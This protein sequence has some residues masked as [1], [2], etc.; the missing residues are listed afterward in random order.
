MTRVENKINL[1]LDS[2]LNHLLPPLLSPSNQHRF[3]TRTLKHT[4]NVFDASFCWISVWVDGSLVFK[5]SGSSLKHKRLITSKQLPK[6]P[7]RLLREIY[8]LMYSSRSESAGNNEI[9]F[10]FFREQKF[11]RF[12]GVPLM[13]VKRLMG[14]LNLVRENKSPAFTPG[15][16]NQLTLL[17]NLLS[18]IMCQWA[19]E[20]SQE[21][22]E[23]TFDSLPQPVIIKDQMHR[24]VAINQ[25]LSDLMGYPQSQILGKSEYDLLPPAQA[26]FFRKKDEEAFRTGKIVDISERSVTDRKGTIHNVQAKRAPLRDP[27]GRITHLVEIMEDTTE[28]KRTERELIKKE[29]IAR[30]RAL[31][32]ND[33][34]TLFIK[35]QVL[36]RACKTIR[37]SGLFQRAVMT[38]HDNTR[39]IIHLGQVGLPPKLIQRAQ[40]APPLERNQISRIMQKRFRISDSFF[41]PVEAGIDF[42]RNRR[43]IP[44]KKHSPPG[45]WQ[46]GD[47]LFVPLRDFSGKVMGYLSVDTPADGCR[48]DIKKVQSLEMLAEAAASRIRELDAQKA[49]QTS[50]DKLKAMFDSVADGITVT[51]LNGK[52]TQSNHS[53]I[54]MFGYKD[55]TEVIGR[56]VFEFIHP[57]DL[58]IAKERFSK[59]AKSGAIASV[60]YTCLKKDGSEFPVELSAAAIRNVRGTPTNLVGILKDITGRKKAEEE[61]FQSQARYKALIEQIPAH[62]YT[63]SVDKI[64][65]SLYISPQVEKLIGYTQGDFRRDPDLW[66]KRLHPADKKRVLSELRHSHA[67]G[68]PFISEYR[69]IHR[70]GNTVWVRDEAMLVLDQKGKPLVL[71]G[72]MTNIT[73]RKSA[74][75]ER[76]KSEEKYR[77]VV[78]NANEAIVVAQEGYL[79][80]VNPKMIEIL[81][82]PEKELLSQPFT[83]FIHPADRKMVVERHWKRIKGEEVPSIYDFRVI[84]RKGDVKWLEINAVTIN[85]GNQPATLNFLTDIT[86]R[87]QD[88]QLKSKYQEQKMLFELTQALSTAGD[89]NQ[90]LKIATKKVVE[91]MGIERSSIVLVNP[92][93][94]SAT[95]NTLYAKKGKANSKLM[96]YTFKSDIYIQL[97][98]LILRKPFVS[99][100]TSLLPHG[101]FLRDFFKQLGIKSNLSVSLISRDK[102][103][104]CINIATKEKHHTF[105]PAEIRLLQMIANTIAVIIENYKF[106]E[107]LKSQSRLLDAQLKEQKMLFELTQALS[108]ATDIKQLKKISVQT[109]AKLMHAERV[110]MGI[111]TAKGDSFNVSDL[112][113]RGKPGHPYSLSL[114]K[115]MFVDQIK[116]LMRRKQPTIVNDTSIYPPGSLEREIISKRGIKSAVGVPLTSHGKVFGF[117]AVSHLSRVHHYSPEEVQLL[118]TISNPI[119]MAIE[120]R[121]LVENLQTQTVNLKKQTQEKD[122]L[123][124]ISQALSQTMDIDGVANTASEVVGKTLGIDRCSIILLTEDGRQVEIRGIFS[125]YGTGAKKLIGK[126][127]PI[128]TEP[129]WRN[130]IARKKALVVNDISASGLGGIIKEHHLKEGLKSLLV[131][132]M[133]FGTKLIGVLALSSLSR[134]RSFSRD[135]IQLSQTIASQIAVALENARLMQMVRVHTHE[136]KELS[137]QLMQAQE[138]ERK[139]IS[140]EMH[141]H[142]GQMLQAIK[143]NLD[144]IKRK[145]TSEPQMLEE[146]ENWF[147]DTEE[148]LSL[149]IDDIR[150][151]IFDL[152]PSI[153]DDFGLYSALK[154]YLDGY[155]RRSDIKVT[156]KGKEEKERFPLKVEENLY[157]IIQESLNNVV[158]HA[159]ATEVGISLYKKHSAVILSVKDNGVGFDPLKLSSSAHPG[160]GISGMRERA[161]L[162]GGSFEVISKPGKGTRINV[163]I[164]LTEVKYEEGQIIDR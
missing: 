129:H 74:E 42:S 44:Q 3:I 27:S 95:F 156:I 51:D 6:L 127:Y 91:L 4:K 8:P 120:N 111:I 12:M 121:L 90:L 2:E 1:T 37:D 9:I 43:Y 106:L 58:K 17:G 116:D 101:S 144:Q 64:S 164:P 15:E 78:E 113:I 68:K 30:E 100:D 142:V 112:L 66:R 94:R 149:T 105:S 62:T 49:L 99:N 22:L 35:D 123:L 26:D 82:Y 136:L 50:E 138:I 160:T 131:T 163:K 34:R 126:R 57:R 25:A 154:S 162:L 158:K 145:L 110:G 46:A 67:T 141:D 23:A 77:L 125:Q 55:K 39:Q 41:V 93:D 28:S 31:L 36:N 103:L 97:R 73:D 10:R 81:G 118:Q 19:K 65:A 114:I 143:M 7:P 130:I 40:Q 86:K 96:D 11:G 108:F 75:E 122:I 88:E 161:N 128:E 32:L 139:R 52:I 102:F 83:K 132:G 63:A 153:L 29:R 70:N 159:N 14:T 69:M 147:I 53:A 20:K 115:P 135:E 45:D 16:L 33:L 48:P 84:T 24:W 87:K 85:W 157:R 119:G 117:L 89:L 98:K 56:N 60:Q 134:S 5:S 76:H 109:V 71:Q 47:E 148:L 150:K 79:K 18:L 133:F 13:S 151:L 137:F 54:L 92:D 124:K 140:Q 80:F 152:R 59:I 21:F 107:D 155:S 72:V 38:I 146:T 61:L 104:G